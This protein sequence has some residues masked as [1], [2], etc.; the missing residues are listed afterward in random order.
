MFEVRVDNVFIE[1]FTRSSSGGCFIATAAYGSYLDPKVKIL[2]DFRDRYLLT[3]TPGKTLVEFYYRHSPPVA[4]YIR[5]REGVRV[6]VRALLSVVVYSIEYPVAALLFLMMPIL[7]SLRMR[8]WRRTRR[9][10]R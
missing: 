8:Q 6:V 7:I 1:N 4:D 3:N 2:R 5:Q 9:S 10:A